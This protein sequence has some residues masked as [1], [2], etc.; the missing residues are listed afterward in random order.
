MNEGIEAQEQAA[1]KLDRDPIVFVV[2]DDQ[3]ARES[4]VA[5]VESN[6][7]PDREAIVQAMN[8]NMCRCGTYGRIVSAIEL[9]VRRMR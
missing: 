8:G 3:A 7:R 4:V 2:D 5:L 6:R 1:S 9:A